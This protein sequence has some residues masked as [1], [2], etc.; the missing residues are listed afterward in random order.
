MYVINLSIETATKLRTDAIP[1]SI[2][3]KELNLQIC[4]SISHVMTKYSNVSNGT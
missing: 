3:T 4:P 1:E 2:S